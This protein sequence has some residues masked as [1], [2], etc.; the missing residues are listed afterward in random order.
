[1]RIKQVLFKVEQV[2][3]FVYSKKGKRKT[4]VAYRIGIYIISGILVGRFRVKYIHSC[5]QQWLTMTP[6]MWNW[7][8]KHVDQRGCQT[9]PIIEIL[10]LHPFLKQ[11]SLPLPVSTLLS[12]TEML[13]VPSYKITQLKCIQSQLEVHCEKYTHN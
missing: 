4:R 10:D 8:S 12:E 3:P 11:S 13:S 1:M 7:K 2:N 9:K 6:I 5:I